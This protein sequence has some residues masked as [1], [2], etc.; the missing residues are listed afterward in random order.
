MDADTDTDN[1]SQTNG[2]PA[3]IECR[4]LYVV[5]PWTNGMEN[6]VRTMPIVQS[7]SSVYELP[8]SMTY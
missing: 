5:W 7:F 2:W 6:I 3:L 1:G 8:T 4:K